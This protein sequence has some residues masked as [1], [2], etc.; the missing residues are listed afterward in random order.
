MKERFF[1]FSKENALC[2]PVGGSQGVAMWFIRCFA[3][4]FR[5]FLHGC[6]YCGFIDGC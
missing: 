6:G 4:D 3:V 5:K 2:L 1:T